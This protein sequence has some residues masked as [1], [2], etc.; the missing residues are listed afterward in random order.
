MNAAY[1]ADEA[2]FFMLYFLGAGWKSGHA[3]AGLR[4]GSGRMG[5]PGFLTTRKPSLRQALLL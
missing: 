4:T 5:S 3:C 1:A 2:G